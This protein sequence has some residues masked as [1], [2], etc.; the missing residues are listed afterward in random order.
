MYSHPILSIGPTRAC[1]QCSGPDMVHV[2]A[3]SADSPFEWRECGDCHH[4]WAIPRDS[5]AA[6]EPFRQHAL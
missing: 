6:F 3:V 5:A 2:S 4:L 1:P